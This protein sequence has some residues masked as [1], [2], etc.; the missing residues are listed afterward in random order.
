MPAQQAGSWMPGS[1]DGG[2]KRHSA[3]S[4]SKPCSFSRGNAVLI[5][6]RN[7]HTNQ[8][9]IR[10][11]AVTLP[12]VTHLTEHLAL[13]SCLPG[14]FGK[15][16]RLGVSP[17]RPQQFVHK[18]PNQG[19][20]WRTGWVRTTA[21][22]CKLWRVRYW[23]LAFRRQGPCCHTG[24]EVGQQI[25]CVLAVAAAPQRWLSLAPLNKGG[26]RAGRSVPLTHL[27][28]PSSRGACFT[29]PCRSAFHRR[30]GVHSI[31]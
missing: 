1:S 27:H 31:D 15:E 5:P 10:R 18:G 12:C 8:P 26:V 23:L 11:S 3:T 20:C 30:P 28:C 7:L 17:R 13:K 2:C 14:M 9:S 16:S 19:R 6:P 21:I 4:K 25:S 29:A 24:G 22:P